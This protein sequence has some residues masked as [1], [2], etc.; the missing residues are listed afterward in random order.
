M[1][2]S[3]NTELSPSDNET[4]FQ[5]NVVNLV[6][7]N[8]IG[9]DWGTT[10][11]RVF[12]MSSDDRVLAENGSNKGMGS[13]A[14]GD[15]EAVLLDLIR[16]WLSE[17]KVIPVIACGMVGARQGWKEAEYRIVPCLPVSD[18]GLM[19]VNTR[20]KRISLHILP[21]LSQRDPSDVMRGEETQLAGFMKMNPRFQG[22]VCLPGT[23]SK[24]VSISGQLVTG[25]KTFM[26]GEL[27]SL[28]SNQSIL[29]HSVN[30][31]GWD[32]SAFVVAALKSVENPDK[33]M[34]ELFKLRASSLLQNVDPVTARSTLSG[35][36]IGQELGMAAD[37]WK[38]QTVALIGAT[39]IAS[40]Y[41]D[42]LVELG[43]DVEMIDAKE[44]ILSGLSCAAKL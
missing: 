27:F 29:R 24:W 38:K 25:F 31:E 40:L 10:N 7:P 19:D 15:F 33:T 22:T 21:G 37:F 42:T 11:V 43:I 6:Q 8:W 9:V 20:D 5:G 13:L 44:A 35:M 14:P 12:A 16:L 28:L 32:V 17:D 23:H 41:A 34:S 26:T 4:N 36:L 1:I 18:Q 3:P 39:E 30:S 2:K